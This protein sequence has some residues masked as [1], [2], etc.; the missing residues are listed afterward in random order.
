MSSWRTTDNA[1]EGAA[2]LHND[3]LLCLDEMGQAPTSQILG[4]AVYMLG[5][6]SAKGRMGRDGSQ[7]PVSMWRLIYL[8]SSETTLADK[9]AED[10]GAKT[11]AGMK[12][13]AID[14]PA[15]PGCGYGLFERIPD[16]FETSRDFADHL[17][18]MA[19]KFYGTAGRAFINLIA[20]DLLGRRK[21]VEE[22]REAFVSSN[23]AKDADGQVKRV[24][25]FFGL[26]AASGE[27]AIELG[28]LPWPQ[29]E[30]LKAAKT[31][32]EAWLAARGSSTEAAEITAGITSVKIFLSAHGMSRCI[33]AWEE[34]EERKAVAADPDAPKWKQATPRERATNVVG[35]REK[36]ERE[37]PVEVPGP[38]GKMVPVDDGYGK[39]ETRTV[40]AWDFYITQE[41][42]P[43]VTQGHDPIAVAKA[44]RDKGLLVPEKGGHLAA[45]KTVPGHGRPRLYHLLARVLEGDDA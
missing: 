10:R 28:I 43:E 8:S 29:G 2:A 40:S 1:L 26:V 45:K 13:R 24:A 18:E 3:C 34:A 16:G 7:K 36:V 31:C 21:I 37:V 11:T 41:A 32:F 12:V 23:C 33:P 30:G 38:D 5:N 39:P 9:I 22:G 27:L 35:F 44:L 15:D 42:W 25:A 4:K 14:I 20:P 6:G 17:V 19:K